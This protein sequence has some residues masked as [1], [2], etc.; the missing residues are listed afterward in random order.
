[1]FTFLL[2]P[3]PPQVQLVARGEREVTTRCLRDERDLD[4]P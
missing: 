2:Q 1:M 3:D 4:A